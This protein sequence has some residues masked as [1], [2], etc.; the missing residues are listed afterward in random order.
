M[1]S[2]AIKSLTLIVFFLGGLS[3]LAQ[4]RCQQVSNQAKTNGNKLLI[5]AFEGLSQY[6]DSAAQQLYHY[7]T[8]GKGPL[9]VLG[10]GTNGG[11]V[12]GGMLSPLVRKY[13]H[14][15]EVVIFDSNATQDGANCG[16]LWMS[17]AKGREL[18]IVGHSW[19]GSDASAAAN[20]LVA[21]GY[22]INSVITVDACF[23]GPISR[24]ARG[25]AYWANFYQ[26]NSG[27][28]RQGY[29]LPNANVDRLVGGTTHMTIPATAPV[30]NTTIARVGTIL[31]RE[32][33]PV[34]SKL[35]PFSK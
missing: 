25:I 7:Q 4:T 3:A 12:T 29:A 16:A 11:L 21:A 9:P 2:F 8:T 22:P 34:A 17:A 1:S 10:N 6:N 31:A 13:G 15:F 27:D 20:A 24:P 26:R 14:G 5:I 33:G 35:S 30:V 23:G 18:L 19:G 28:L 32:N